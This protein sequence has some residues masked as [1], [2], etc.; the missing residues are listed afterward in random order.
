MSSD[1]RQIQRLLAN[2]VRAA[3]N[4]DSAAQA[5]HFAPGA[6]TEMF[7][8]VDG[9]QTLV[10]R[11][12][13]PEEVAWATEK[14]LAP[15]PAGGRSHHTTSDHIIDVSGDEGH[16]SAQFIVFETVAATSPEDGWPVG[17]RGVQGTVRPSES[18]FYESDV[19]RIDGE[20]RIVHHRIILD[21]PF[22]L[23]VAT[24]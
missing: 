9:V 10:N 5:A 20:W 15:H 12:T 14:V 3:D 21:M 18:G 23:P 24:R 4:R 13:S 1:E 6:I 7:S 2:Y 19:R 17:V 11:L 22:A 16:I 8:R